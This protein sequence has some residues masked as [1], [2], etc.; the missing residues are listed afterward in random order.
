MVKVVSAPNIPAGLTAV[1]ESY[2][3][4][5]WWRASMASAFPRVKVFL[6]SSQFEAT[7]VEMDVHDAPPELPLRGDPELSHREDPTPA[8][9]D[10]ANMSSTSR[11]STTSG[12]V[13]AWRTA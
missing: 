2:G 11:S 1:L 6:H 8:V 12:S 9:S 10:S 4:S 5:C 3:P 7:D 13:A